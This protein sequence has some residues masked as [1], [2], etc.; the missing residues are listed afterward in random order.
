MLSPGPQ[1][2]FFI[3]LSRS[4]ALDAAWAASDGFHA[5]LWVVALQCSGVRVALAGG[6]TARRSVR[7][8]L[9]QPFFLHLTSSPPQSPPCS[10]HF[11]A[12]Y[13]SNCLGAS[14][15]SIEIYLI[16]FYCS[17]KTL[18]TTYHFLKIHLSFNLI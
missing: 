13:R 5:D 11:T 18:L 7:K 16:F 4:L 15:F 1:V 9:V 17:F 10:K 8:P 14:F 6:S 3:L 2:L 12:L